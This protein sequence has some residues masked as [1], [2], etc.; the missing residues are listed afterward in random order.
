MFLAAD[1]WK[2]HNILDIFNIRAKYHP[3]NQKYDYTLNSSV[4]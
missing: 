1:V 4:S 3:S 2:V